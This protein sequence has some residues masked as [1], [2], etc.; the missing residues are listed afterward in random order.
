MGLFGM[1][2]PTA[3][4]CLRGQLAVLGRIA[5]GTTRT[6]D[7]NAKA[8]SP[9]AS[10]KRYS[11]EESWSKMKEEKEDKSDSDSSSKEANSSQTSP[12]KPPVCKQQ[13]QTT[14]AA[15]SNS[16]QGLI[17]TPQQSDQDEVNAAIDLFQDTV[18]AS[19]PMEELVVGF[20]VL[21]NPLKPKIFLCIDTNYRAKWM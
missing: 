6:T 3:W 21:E 8:N 11:R 13:F 19:L 16:T 12:T 5:S 20:S 7:S 1:I 17:A 15:F 14:G 9:S 2:F 18:A 4:D 10:P